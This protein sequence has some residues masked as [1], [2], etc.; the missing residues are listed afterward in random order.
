[1]AMRV[2]VGGAGLGAATGLGWGAGWLGGSVLGNLLFPAKGADNRIEGP[3]LG[4]LG[5]TSA[6]H[7]APIPIGFGTLRLAGNLIWSSG[8]R[9]QRRVQR[10]EVGKGGGGASQTAVSYAYT[11]SFAI[12]FGEGPA[13]DVLRIWAH[14]ML[15]FDRTGTGPTTKP[16]LRFRF[17]KGDET[18]LPDPLIE[19]QVGIG[20]AP[21]HRGLAYLV[22]E[23]LP[24]ADFGNTI[25]NITAE[26]A[27]R[28]TASQPYQLLDRL[29]LAEGGSL[30]GYQADELAVDWRRGKGWFLTSDIDPAEAGLRRFDL[31][32]MREDR[33]ARM[34]EVCS[35]TPANFP[36]ALC[37]G[38]DGQLYLTVGAGNALPIIRIDPDALREVARFGSTGS[39]L[40][41]TTSRFVATRFMGV[42]SAYGLDGRVDFLLTGSILDDIGLLRTRDLGYV[43]GAAETVARGKVHGCVGGR[44]EA[45]LGEG[46]ILASGSGASHTIIDLYR[47]RVSAMAAYDPAT[48]LTV[49]VELDQVA[50]I[51]PGE[52]EP[53]STAFWEAAGGL[54]YDPSD[55]G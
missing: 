22:I 37:C 27:W 49:G 8:I 1:M 17:H 54:A 43:W 55:D 12:G 46:W 18:Q 20:R 11:A 30:D 51:D 14:G 29:D 13:D 3:R 4:D 28:R 6:A 42:V 26:I 34:S 33:Q 48:G 5:V 15:I 39:G 25:P 23:D 44:V 19:S 40:T 53:G 21:A 32:T 31:A 41:N 35:D 24:L 52:V 38:P 50:A 47:L 16:G 45:G 9:E 10:S 7:G 2:A 36:S